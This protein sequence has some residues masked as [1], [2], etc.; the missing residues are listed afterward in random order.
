[1]RTRSTQ[2]LPIAP[3]W[4]RVKPRISATSTAM[5][6]AADT[7]FWTVRPSICVRWLIVVSPPYA[8]QFVLVPKLTAVLSATSG[9]TAAQAGAVQR[10]PALEALERVDDQDAR[11]R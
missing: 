9:F 5:P 7:K 4:R 3:A 2:K 6:V 10:Q 11:R 1:M 8:C